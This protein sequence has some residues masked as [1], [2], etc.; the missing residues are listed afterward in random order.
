M[1]TILDK[2]IINL[3]SQHGDRLNGSYNSNVSFYFHNLLKAEKSIAYVEVGVVSAEIPVSFYTINEYN[4]YFYFEYKLVGGSTLVGTPI[5]NQGNYSATTFITEIKRAINTII[6]SL[7]V[8]LIVQLDR[9][10]GLLTW[11]MPINSVLDE[12]SFLPSGIY[13]PLYKLIGFDETSTSPIVLLPDN[14]FTNIYPINLLGI[15][16][17]NIGSNN[18]QTYNYDSGSSGFSNIVASIE[19]N[20]SPYGIVLYRNQSLTYNI[21][22]VPELDGFTIELKDPDGNFIDFNNLDWTITLGMN[23]YRYM[24]QFSQTSFSDVLAINPP[25]PKKEEPAMNDL[26]VLTYKEKL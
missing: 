13:T 3:A 15:N 17:I 26:D 22:R 9:L 16:K 14:L 19:V 25:P 1:A 4:K 6:N 20:A 5:L 8:Y 21:L 2:R 23:I 7:D 24:P 10:T 18:L 12:I 11:T